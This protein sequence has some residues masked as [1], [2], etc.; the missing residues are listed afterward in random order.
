MTDLLS[1]IPHNQIVPFDADR[2]RAVA[3]H[4]AA[5]NSGNVLA[6]YL[7]GLTDNS[8]AAIKTD[9]RHFTNFLQATTAIDDTIDYQVFQNNPQAWA[10]VNHALVNLFKRYQLQQGF[11]IG[12]INR[13]LSTIRTYAELAFQA[14]VI[15]ATTKDLIKL[16]G[17]IRAKEGR[18]LDANRQGATRID[19]AGAKKADSVTISPEHAKL[20]KTAHPNTAQG[21]KDRLL[22]CLLLDLGLRASEVVDLQVED[23]DMFT[24]T[25]KVYRVKTDSHSTLKMTYDVRQALKGYDMP[26]SGKLLETS[27]RSLTQRVCDLGV[28]YG[29]YTEEVTE[30]GRYKSGNAVKKRG[31]LS[32]HDC[33]HYLA[34]KL[35]REGLGV[36]QLMEAMGW[37][38]LSTAQRYIEQSAIANSAAV[39]IIDR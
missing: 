26:V 38:A 36:H 5:F 21:R 37:S 31:T 9:L 1:P 32:A 16:V 17:N 24:E 8:K 19:R 34:T 39:A 14:G 6:E 10:F 18:N 27:T 3:A 11:A 13:K 25:I 20:L 23:V 33:R 7:D 28:K 12:S 4:A 22:M 15:D 35:S 2:F 29:Y 30:D